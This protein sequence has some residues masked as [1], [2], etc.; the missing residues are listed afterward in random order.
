MTY[1]I[2]TAAV[3]AVALA[4]P[5]LADDVIR[6]SGPPL[7]VRAGTGTLIQTP[8]MLGNVFIADPTVADVQIPT[9]GNL[10]YVFGKKAG[11]TSLFALSEDGQVALSRVVEVSGP[12][13]VRVLRGKEEQIWAEV[14]GEPTKS[15]TSLTD[16]P[17]GSAVSIPVG[18]PAR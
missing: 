7:E 5:A 12:K 14:H 11:K 4:A 9:Q 16:L 15:G 1:R 13:T 2:L 10:I 8:G 6:P 18:A 17:P 3:L